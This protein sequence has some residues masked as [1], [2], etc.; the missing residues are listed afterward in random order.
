MGSRL[1]PLSQVVPKQFLPLAEKPAFYYL[2]KEVKESGIKEVTFVTQ[3]GNEKIKEYFDP[4]SEIIEAL[5]KKGKS[6]SKDLNEI[7]EISEEISFSVVVQKEPKG[8]GNALLKAQKKIGKNP[9]AVL[10]ADDIVRSEKPAIS[11]LNQTFKT[12]QKPVLGLKNMPKEKISDYGVAEVEKIARRLFK[13]KD[14]HEKPS[15]EEAPSNLAVFGR[16]ILTPEIFDYLKEASVEPG[17]EKIIYDGLLKMRSDGKVVYGY[18]ID[19]NWLD[20]G[21]K[22]KY[23]KANLT[24][25]LNHPDY[26]DELKK[27][28]NELK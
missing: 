12:S 25:C 2:V 8:N 7:R 17:E 24:Y 6:F 1:F 21:T 13:V 19:G 3:P 16:F 20:C 14:I 15:P 11:Q 26:G 5:K 28:I 4:S 9:F 23:L 22:L 10:F 27:Y 18:E